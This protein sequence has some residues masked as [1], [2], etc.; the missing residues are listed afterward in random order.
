[1]WERETLHLVV[2]PRCTELNEIHWG[3]IYFLL[4][5]RK[6]DVALVFYTEMHRVKWDSL[7]FNILCV[8]CEKESVALSCYTEMH[9]VK[10]DSLRFNILSVECEIERRCTWLF[11]PRCTEAKEIHRGFY[12]LC[13]ECERWRERY[14]NLIK[15]YL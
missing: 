11:T 12:L 5:V 8:E 4:N 13:V 15:E 3:L 1:M 7:R 2:T 10:W 9:W 6:R 14:I